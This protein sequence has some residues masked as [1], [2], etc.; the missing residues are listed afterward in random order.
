MTTAAEHKTHFGFRAVDEGD[1]AGLVGAVFR[2]VAGRY[3]L[4]NDLMSFGAHRL[5]KRFAASQSGLRRGGWA[6]DVAAGSGDMA[7]RLARQVGVGGVVMLTDINPA[8]LE[9]GKNN[10]LDAGLAGYVDTSGAALD[11]HA[12]HAAI[13]YA[14]ADAEKLCFAEAQFHCVCI[15]FGLRNVTRQQD[16]LASMYR[17]I[18]PG[19]RL[20]VL[21]FSKPVLPLLGRAYDFYSFNAIPKLGK[22]VAGDEASYRYL[23]ESI[24]RHPNQ[25]T[26]KTMLQH[27]GFDDIRIHNLSGG[28]V[29]VH[30]GLKY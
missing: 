15:A 26:L 19:G 2:S 22:L 5:W 16:A 9:A 17:V 4:M 20:V 24:R 27:A 3:D 13:G 23:V 14:L 8:M 21:E 28:I 18:R 29:A 11:S 1:K 10:M 12:A 7:R 30:I 25:Q 6:L